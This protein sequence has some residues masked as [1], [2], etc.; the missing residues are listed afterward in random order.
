MLLEP[1]GAVVETH[2]SSDEN[3]ASPATTFA[4]ASDI[5][6]MRSMRSALLSIV[7]PVHN[8][9]GSIRSFLDS[10]RPVL[11]GLDL[12]WNILFVDDGSRDATAAR[13]AAERLSDPRIHLLSLS[14]NFGKEAA[15]TA[16]IDH[17]AGDAVIV[18]DVDLQDPPDLI[19]LMVSRW[20]EGFEVVCAV[21]R[22][23]G[24]D[25]A[26]K[27]ATA[28]QFYAL[29]NRISAVKI[30]H[31][32]GDFRLLDRRAVEALKAIPE[33]VRFMKGLFAWVGFKTAYV[34]YDRPCRQAGETKF[35]YWRLW[36]FAI[37]GIT[38]FSTV[39]LR[40]WTYFGLTIALLSFLYGCF[41]VA[42]TLLHGTD[43]PGYASL[44]VAVLFLGGIQLIGL[45]I[46][47]EYLG[48]VFTEVKR[49][50]VYLIADRDSQRGAGPGD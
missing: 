6:A 37:D 1:Q 18:M 34:E 36:N 19:P 7:V 39:P 16:G 32:A 5:G 41:L 49:R 17:A 21:R 8:E 4:G 29:Y 33:R 25:T 10:V 2:S 45:G 43:V 11:D 26:L 46:I 15:L 42:R 13:I 20:R 40:I 47:G 35:S 23:R 14:R 9:E 28:G 22:A 48:R 31:N 24:S 38:S 50:P 3:E 30:P 27:R 12:R 44:I